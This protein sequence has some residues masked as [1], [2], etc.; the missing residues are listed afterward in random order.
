MEKMGEEKLFI[1]FWTSA[2]RQKARL[3]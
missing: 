2:K 1:P 3:G